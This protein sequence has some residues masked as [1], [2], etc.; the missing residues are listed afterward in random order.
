MPESCSSHA[1]A[2]TIS[3]T[4]RQGT[5]S[6][7][8]C[9]PAEVR[10]TIYHA[11]LVD[12]EFFYVPLHATGP[13]PLCTLAQPPLTRVNKQLRE[14]CLPVYY[15]NNTFLISIRQTPA[16][17]HE[18]TEGGLV[19][20]FNSFSL[21]RNGLPRE[22]NLRFIQAMELSWL[23]TWR[24]PTESTIFR[25]SEL[26]IS[27][28]RGL[29]SEYS[30]RVLVDYWSQPEIEVA[31]SS[32]VRRSWQLLTAVAEHRHYFDHQNL[33][34]LIYITW[35]CGMNC[36][37]A[38]HEVHLCTLVEGLRSHVI[39]EVSPEATNGD[40]LGVHGKSF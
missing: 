8:L 3:P 28:G 18:I 12:G 16:R 6:T 21:S 30:A 22:N 36:P 39:M 15:A 13:I 23:P 20:L 37:Q 34:R 7:L 9:L 1:G 40:R 11:A 2:A 38:V 10:N 33:R 31:V 35:L 5:A 14:E 32:A 19:R 27:F 29:D 4:Q 25:I 24:R 26:R 17:R